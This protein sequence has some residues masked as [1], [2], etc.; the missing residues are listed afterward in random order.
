MDAK[1][2]RV[3]ISLATALLV[4][5]WLYSQVIAW[6]VL[7]TVALGQLLVKVIGLSI[8]AHIVIFIVISIVS[9]IIWGKVEK[10]VTD[11]RDAEIELYAM[12]L[13]LVCFSLGMIIT[14]AMMGWQQLGANAALLSIFVCMYVANIAGDILKLFWYR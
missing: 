3:F 7:E 13:I 4:G 8:A 10:D 14:F 11:E 9:G 6:P 12:R 5:S 2:R 1:R